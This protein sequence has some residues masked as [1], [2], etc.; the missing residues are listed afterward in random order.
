MSVSGGNCLSPLQTFGKGFQLLIAVNVLPDFLQRH[1]D[2]RYSKMYLSLID[3][4]YVCDLS[5]VDRTEH[6]TK[7]TSYDISRKMCKDFFLK[8]LD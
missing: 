5:A 1:L 7:C 6:P 2:I 8:S 4:L 3:R